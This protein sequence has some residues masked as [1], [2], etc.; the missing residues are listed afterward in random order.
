VKAYRIVFAILSLA[1]AS[2]AWA[3][4]LS[5]AATAG[6]VAELQKLGAMFPQ[7][8]T[9][10]PA[11]F[12]FLPQ[13]Q[14]DPDE[15]GAMGTYQPNG[16]TVVAA[17][18]FFRSLGTNGR[19]CFTCHQPQNG[20]ALSAGSAQKRFDADPTDPLF[21]LVDGA[22]CP[23]ADLSNPSAAYALLLKRGLIRIGLPMQDAM[24]FQ[25]TGVQ[26]DPYNCSTNPVTGL[27]GAKSGFLSFYRRPLPST[28]LNV[29]TSIMWDGREPDLFH[30]AVDAT[31]GHAEGKNAP[32]APL[33]KQI[34]SLEGCTTAMTS[35]ACSGIPAG[36][37]MVTAQDTDNSAGDL[38]AN[39]A[40]GGPLTLADAIDDFYLHI[41]D[42]FAGGG[43]SFNPVIFTRYSAWASLTGT[44]PQ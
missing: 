40:T 7:A 27:T 5:A 17:S 18:P 39:G 44:D 6:A 41:N 10:Q 16:A 26:D 22:V 30:Q 29:L 9:Q 31:L 38:T 21:R 28:N 13:Y 34:V 12:P 11:N 25:I 15:N 33:Q 37:G 14:S 43:Q 35:A 19:T 3:D 20:W 24:Q 42:P 8:P 32:P 23:S 1:A 4:D 2:P 36:E